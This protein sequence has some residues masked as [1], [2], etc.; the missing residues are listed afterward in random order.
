MENDKER[1]SQ[2]ETNQDLLITRLT[3][4]E[5]AIQQLWDNIHNLDEKVNKIG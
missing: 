4:A 3:Q 1:I 5:K 2:L